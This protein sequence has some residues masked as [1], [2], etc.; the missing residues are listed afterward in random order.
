MI[1]GGNHFILTSFRPQDR[2]GTLINLV[3]VMPV[4]NEADGLE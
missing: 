4:Y 1:G 3:V 2:V